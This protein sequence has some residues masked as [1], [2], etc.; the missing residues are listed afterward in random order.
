MIRRPP[1]STRTDTLFPYTTLF[2]S[3]C[4]SS[5][6]CTTRCSPAGFHDTRPPR[7]ECTQRTHFPPRRRRP[8]RSDASA[9]GRDDFPRQERHMSI[10]SPIRISL[11]QDGDYAFRVQFHDTDLLPLLTDDSDRKS[12]EHTSELQ[13]LMRISYAVFCVKKKKYNRQNNI[14]K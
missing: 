4:S 14:Q 2:R 5:R 6:C 11:E 7:R 12:K 10:D 8:G 1:R 3:P 9:C 13:S